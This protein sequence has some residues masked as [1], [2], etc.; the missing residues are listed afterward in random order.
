[1]E[2]QN[3]FLLVAAEYKIVYTIPTTDDRL[4]I[5]LIIIII[6]IIMAT[7]TA[8]KRIP[9]YRSTLPSQK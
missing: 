5:I 9:G 7:S 4:R 3:F 1:M 6:I 2:C 8:Y